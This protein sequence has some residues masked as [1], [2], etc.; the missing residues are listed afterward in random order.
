MGN[1][2]QIPTHMPLFEYL[3]R[4][5]IVLSEWGSSERGLALAHAL[6]FVELLASFEVRVLGMEPWRKEGLAYRCDSQWVWEPANNTD[7]TEQAKQ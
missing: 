4:N 1:R 2:T 5:G 3:Q 7:T 6:E